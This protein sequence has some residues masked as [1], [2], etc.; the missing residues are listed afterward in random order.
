MKD[1]FEIILCMFAVYGGFRLATGI[2]AALR[3]RTRTVIAVRAKKG[4]SADALQK[5]L[6]GGAALSLDAPNMESTPVLLCETETDAHPYLATGCACYIRLLPGTGGDFC[7]GK[8]FRHTSV[9]P[10]RK[11]Q[12]RHLPKQR[13]R[14]RHF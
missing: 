13:K 4:E 9:R 8:S 14:I 10:Q 11:R 3:A 1:F 2:G 7:D 5:R 6:A 12:R